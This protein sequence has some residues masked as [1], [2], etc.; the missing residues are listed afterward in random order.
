MKTNAY[1]FDH[2][3]NT[4][5]ITKAFKNAASKLGSPEYKIILELRRD[6]PDMKIALVDSTAKKNAVPKL[7]Y[8]QMRHFISQCCGAEERLATY[9]R[10]YSLSQVQPS[11]YHYM[12]AWFLDNYA[13]YSDKPEFD[14]DGFVIVKTKAQMDAEKKAALPQSESANSMSSEDK[15]REVNAA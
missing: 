12:K 7:S 9:E 3:T 4:L 10:V 1:R 5:N 6:N 8:K 11:P 13:N 2:E 14:A 15:Q